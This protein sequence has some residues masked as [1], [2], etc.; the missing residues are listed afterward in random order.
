VSVECD[1]HGLLGIA[2]EECL[3]QRRRDTIEEA[4]RWLEE[5]TGVR[6]RDAIARR[7]VAALLG[8]Q[9]GEAPAKPGCSCPGGG[10]GYVG[11]PSLCRSCGEP[12]TAPAEGAGEDC[13]C[14][15]NCGNPWPTCPRCN[16]TGGTPARSR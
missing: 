14:V 2:C 9:A 7:M 8:K 6:D 11:N 12:R 10:S 1:K 13:D 16:G 5:Q 3:S 4:A 15:S